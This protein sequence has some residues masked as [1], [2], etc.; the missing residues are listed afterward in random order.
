MPSAKA[1][2][3]IGA[4]LRRL[5]GDAVELRY[6]DAADPATTATHRALLDELRDERLPLPVT[7]IDGQVRFTGAIDPLRVVAAVAEELARR[8]G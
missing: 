3:A 6:L 1:A 2:A 5:Y 4:S 8:A 7:L